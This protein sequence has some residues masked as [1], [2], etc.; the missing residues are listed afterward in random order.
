[1]LNRQFDIQ[2][3]L[4]LS[5]II[6]LIVNTMF[7]KQ[8]SLLLLF[9]RKQVIE[10]DQDISETESDLEFREKFDSHL[11]SKDPWDRIFALYRIFSIL[12]KF[13]TEGLDSMDYSL[14]RGV[15]SRKYH[16]Y[17]YLEKGQRQNDQLNDSFKTDSERSPEDC[18][19][20]S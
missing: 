11:N 14:I 5:I 8:Q 7:T 20:Q 19:L 13:E 1:M 12:K 6:K 18:D 16:N 2:N 15:Y 17:S 3:L 4:K 9:Q 10:P